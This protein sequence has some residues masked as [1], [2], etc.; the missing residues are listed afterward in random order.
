MFTLQ[1]TA[2]IFCMGIKHE[3]ENDYYLSTM[4]GLV[5][6]DIFTDYL[7]MAEHL[8]TDHYYIPAA[9]IVGSTLEEH[10]RKLCQKN[11]LLLSFTDAKGKLH[12]KTGSDFNIDLYKAEVYNKIEM[13]LVESWQKIRNDAAHG[14]YDQFNEQQVNYMLQ[15]V[16][17]FIGRNLL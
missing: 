11:N 13:G 10:L 17:E 1:R 16:K 9:V 3:I 4:R 8:L 7:D 12:F 15:G 14:N 5:S 6:A 2:D